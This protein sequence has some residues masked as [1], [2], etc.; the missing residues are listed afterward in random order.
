MGAIIALVAP[1]LSYKEFLDLVE[2]AMAE[3][4][5]ELASRVSNVEITVETDPVKGKYDGLLGLYEGIPLTHRETGYHA[6]L[7][8]RITLFKHNIEQAAADKH[9]VAEVIRETVLHEIAHHF[10]IDDQRLE[11]L[12]WA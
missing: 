4:P 10:G 11:E 8:D 6:V 12:G 5:L 9:E 7:P 3:L 1:R 2:E